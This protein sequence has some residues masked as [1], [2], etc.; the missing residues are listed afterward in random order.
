MLCRALI[1]GPRPS[2]SEALI[3][4]CCRRSPTRVGASAAY[5][6]SEQNCRPAQYEF[7]IT[8]SQGRFGPVGEP[9]NNDSS[10]EPIASILFAETHDGNSRA[11]ILSNWA[12]HVV[13]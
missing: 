9:S 5:L 1:R 4:F 8:P 6:M 12:L 7:L 13:R 10:F 3:P 2:V 11:E